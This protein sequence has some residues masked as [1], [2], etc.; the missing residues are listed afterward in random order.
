[1]GSARALI[2]VLLLAGMSLP[3]SGNASEK[4]LLVTVLD[5]SG[6]PIRNLEPAEFI[7]REDGERRRII[8]AKPATD[9]LV[10]VVLV[11]T[12]KPIAGIQFPT[13]DLRRSL[14]T[15]AKTLHA[16]DPQAELAI[17]E[18]AGAAVMTVPF[19]TRTTDVESGVARLVPSQR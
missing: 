13:Q 6:A 15:F 2:P 1:M 11:D 17:Y 7:V 5:E 3:G 4:T 19:T 8:S 14:T 9:P 10:V 16:G 12:A 18:L